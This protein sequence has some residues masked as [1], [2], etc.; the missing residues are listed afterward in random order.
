MIESFLRLVLALLA[1]VFGPLW[2]IVATPVLWLGQKFVYLWRELQK[3]SRKSTARELADIEKAPELTFTRMARVVVRSIPFIV[4]MLRHIL[5]LVILGFVLEV[6]WEIAGAISTDIWDNKVLVN[7]KIQPYQTLILLVDDSYVNPEFLTEDSDGGTEFTAEEK[8]LTVEQRKVVRNRMI[9]WF[10]FGNIVGIL[11][12]LMWPYYETWIW[13]NVNQFLRVSMIERLE[14][15]SLSFHNEN[16]AGDAIFRIYQDSA[17]IV[18]VI[19]EAILGPFEIIRSVLLAMIIVFFL[20]LGLLAGIALAFIPMLALT[21]WYTPRIRRRSVTNR[22]ENSNLTSTIQESFI[23]LKVVK[24]CRAERLIQNRFNRDSHRALDAALMLRLDMVILSTI[25]MF[26]GGT[27]IVLAE[28]YMAQWVMENRE[29]FLG[30]WF[31]ALVG[32]AFW[33]KGA[34]EKGR[35]KVGESVHSAFGL[36]RVWCMMQDLFLGLERAFYFLDLEPEV[37]DPEGPKEYPAQISQVTWNDVHFGYKPETPVLKG[38]NLEAKAGQITAIVGTTGCGKSTLMS[39]LLRLYDPQD[40]E[41]RVNDVNLKDLKID[42][43]RQHIAIALQKNILFSGSVAYNIGYGADDATAEQILAAAQV[44]VAD[45]FIQE[46]DRGYSTELG[47]RGNKLSSGQRQRISI[48]RAVLKDAPILVLDEPTASLDAETEQRVLQNLAE[49]GQAK[50]VFLI[51]HRLSTIRNAD[52]IAFMEDG[53]IEE[54]GTHDDLLALNGKYASFVQA[55]V[56]GDTET[57]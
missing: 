11:L 46:M 12:G 32:F 55:E 18:N 34:F 35:E 31:V 19:Q 8:R 20:D 10:I 16:R 17:M 43:I 56:E 41:I 49:W 42:D 44:A 39:T 54:I 38:I 7:Q 27:V 36:V 14:Y 26:F 21:I 5:F 37:Q 15:L 30:G 2:R 48:A 6:I 52:Q 3:W 4:P 22:V 57:A 13:Q 29:T 40:G 28:F 45:E 50:V 53:R 33:N 24:A 1:K 9:G 25:C 47:E 23:A 51:T